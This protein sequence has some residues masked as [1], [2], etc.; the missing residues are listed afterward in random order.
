MV[1]G[2]LL[3]TWIDFLT[4]ELLGLGLGT[5]VFIYRLRLGL[6]TNVDAELLYLSTFGLVVRF[7]AVVVS[8]LYEW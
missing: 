1:L 2:L 3:T 6:F 5:A 4:R 7:P 8:T